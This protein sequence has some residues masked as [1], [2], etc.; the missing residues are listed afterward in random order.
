LPLNDCAVDDR[1][2]EF[3][4]KPLEERNG[5]SDALSSIEKTYRPV[6]RMNQGRCDTALN[7]STRKPLE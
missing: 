6:R 7:M 5:R 1:G 4:V 2:E 3:V